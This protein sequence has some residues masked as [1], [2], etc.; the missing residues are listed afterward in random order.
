MQSAYDSFEGNKL[1]EET[2][3]LPTTIWNICKCP[4]CKT[5]FNMLL[6]KWEDAST[7]CPRCSRIII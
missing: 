7:T 5:K 6:V 3:K 4:Y 2:Q 1:L